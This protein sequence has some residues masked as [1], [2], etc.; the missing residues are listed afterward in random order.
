M[1]NQRI[2]DWINEKLEEGREKEDIESAL[3]SKGFSDREIDNLIDNS[4]SNRLP[5]LD[6]PEF[7][8][9][10]FNYAIILSGLL[11]VTGFIGLSSSP[12]CEPNLKIHELDGDNESLKINYTLQTERTQ[13]YSVSNRFYNEENGLS[14]NMNKGNYKVNNSEKGS[15]KVVNFDTSY[16]PLDK[17][18]YETIRVHLKSCDDVIYLRNEKEDYIS[19]NTIYPESEDINLER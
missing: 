12:S 13:E 11:L 9:K 19:S 2:N 1:G 5:D 18:R 10:Y 4:K 16:V 6:K 8:E 15:S 17:F 14:L 3:R 7:G